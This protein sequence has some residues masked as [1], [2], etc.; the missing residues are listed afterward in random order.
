M[1]VVLELPVEPRQQHCFD[2]AINA[3][4]LGVTF[5]ASGFHYDLICKGRVPLA[6]HQ[7]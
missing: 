5:G 4:L 3:K 2:H 7:L 6:L 1:T